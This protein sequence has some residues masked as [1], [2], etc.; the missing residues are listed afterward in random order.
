MLFIDTN[1][2]LFHNTLN[3][4]IDELIVKKEQLKKEIANDQKLINDLKDLDNYEA[5]ARENFFMK[6]KDEEIFII[7]FKDSIEN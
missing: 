3:S 7:E 2:Y 4:E 1:S 6:K 5:F